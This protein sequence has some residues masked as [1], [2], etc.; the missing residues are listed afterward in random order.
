MPSCLSP[1]DAMS[2]HK[3]RITKHLCAHGKVWWPHSMH[4][5]LC[6]PACT[7]ARGRPLEHARGGTCSAPAAA[8]GIMAAGMARSRS[9]SAP[10][11]SICTTAESDG[12][13]TSSPAPPA[14]CTALRAGRA[15]SGAAGAC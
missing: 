3:K 11:Q 2:I 15:R 7:Q 6:V 4:P 14:A 8:G 13:P 5:R 9:H 10:V 12:A 1:C